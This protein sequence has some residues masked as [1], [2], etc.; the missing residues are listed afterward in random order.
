MT[1]NYEELHER[2]PSTSE[3]AFQILRDRLLS[4]VAII[5]L[6]VA[7]LVLIGIDLSI[8]RWARLA[9]LT[10]IV[11]TPFAYLV[12]QTLLNMLPDPPGIIFVDLDARK[13]DASVYWLS[14]DDFHDLDILEG[15]LNQ[16]SP[17]LYLGKQ[18]DLENKTAIGTWRGTMS[19]RELLRGLQKVHECRGQLEDDAKKGFVLETQAFTII[20]SAVRRT[21]ETVIS[22]FESGTLPDEGEGI[23]TSVDDALEQFDLDER[24]DDELSDLDDLDESDEIIDPDDD[25]DDDLEDHQ[26]QS[27][28][29][30]PHEP[31]L[32]TN[33]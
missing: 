23:G 24:I 28:G 15:E 30:T 16:V 4:I 22:T 17:K 26:D 3:L 20:R 12:A 18:L 2:P 9:G 6:L 13:M 14:L 19:D 33:D 25:L 31:T 11:T 5:L 8:P 1:D 7:G 32:R 27:N 21:T 29:E 10:A